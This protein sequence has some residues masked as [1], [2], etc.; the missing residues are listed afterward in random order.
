MLCISMKAGDYFTV[1]S[2]TVIQLERLDGERIHL[3]IHAPREIPI[4]RGDV[5]E[6]GGGQRPACLSRSVSAG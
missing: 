6:R 1:G 5:L 2:D 3:A 4:L